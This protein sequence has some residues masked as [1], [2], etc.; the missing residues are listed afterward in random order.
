MRVVQ[1][2]AGEIPEQVHISLVLREGK[3]QEEE[4]QMTF[5]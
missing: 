5:L 3:T 4:V 2:V 1:K